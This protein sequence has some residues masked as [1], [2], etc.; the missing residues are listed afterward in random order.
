[1]MDNPKDIME[2]V[3]WRDDRGSCDDKCIQLAILEML[4]VIAESLLYMSK[5]KE[6]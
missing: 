4:G 2:R 1:M 5:D 3:M 6:I